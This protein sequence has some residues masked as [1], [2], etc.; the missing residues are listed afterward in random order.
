M[1]NE[2][3]ESCH[4]LIP[5]FTVHP[6]LDLGNKPLGAIVQLSEH[7]EVWSLGFS[8]AKCRASVTVDSQPK[9]SYSKRT[10]LVRDPVLIRA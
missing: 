1:A 9:A 8:V 2:Y 7:Q 3:F 10:I 6:S 4:Y 5:C